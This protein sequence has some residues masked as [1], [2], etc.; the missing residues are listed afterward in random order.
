MSNL[1]SPKFEVKDI[2]R[3]SFN[4]QYNKYK[5]EWDESRKLPTHPNGKE[6]NLRAMKSLLDAMTANA[7]TNAKKLNADVEQIFA[8][9]VK[10]EEYQKL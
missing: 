1:D 8:T 10:S 5:Q 6:I 9:F 2:S 4:A 3:E 7:D